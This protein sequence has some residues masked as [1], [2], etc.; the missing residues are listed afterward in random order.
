MLNLFARARR[1]G[2][3]TAAIVIVFAATYAA[4][5]SAD[6][7]VL[8][9]D[10]PV[11]I[12]GT[13]PLD[14]EKLGTEE[15]LLQRDIAFITRRTAGDTSLSGEDAGRARAGAARQGDDVRGQGQQDKQGDS[16]SGP[17]T[18]SAPWTGLGP[19]PIVQVTRSGGGRGG[20]GGGGGRRGG[21]AEH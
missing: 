20:G 12:P 3:L 10:A 8:D 4:P 17:V 7:D 14:L 2:A 1:F 19:T 9:P 11:Y 21:A 15:L 13:Q 6:P 18:F 16:R 5:A